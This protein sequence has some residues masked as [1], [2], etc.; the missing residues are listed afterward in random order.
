VFMC[1][2]C[3]RAVLIFSVSIPMFTT[4]A[5]HLSTQCFMSYFPLF[6]SNMS[7]TLLYQKA[8]LGVTSSSNAGTKG[9]RPT[10]CHKDHPN[11][12]KLSTTELRGGPGNPGYLEILYLLWSASGPQSV[13]ICWVPLGLKRA[14]SLL[15]C[16]LP[17][18]TFPLRP[19][20]GQ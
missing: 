14:R 12:H 8:L 2:P 13:N 18:V 19:L 10:H 7:Q 9:M 6:L 11:L 1:H 16:E 4:G 20:L 3:T 17:W 5:V 15:G